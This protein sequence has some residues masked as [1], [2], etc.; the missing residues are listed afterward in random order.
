LDEPGIEPDA[1]VTASS[2]V[3][4]EIQG[5]L[6]RNYGFHLNYH[7]QGSVDPGAPAPRPP[8]PIPPWHLK[9][10]AGI[11]GGVPPVFA[12]THAALQAGP[13]QSSRAPVVDDDD[14]IYAEIF[15][16]ILSPPKKKSKT[17]KHFA[18]RISS[19]E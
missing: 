2:Y 9:A 11:S 7:Y 4:C 18:A 12:D 8:Y 16:P 19:L 6:L 3:Q 5:F 17:G 14:P 10:G 13:K 1:D 15:D